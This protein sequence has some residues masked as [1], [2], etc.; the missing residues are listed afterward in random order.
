MISKIKSKLFKSSKNYSIDDIKNKISVLT[1]DHKVIAMCPQSTDGNWKGVN[2]ATSSMFHNQWLEIPQYYS[3]QVVSDEHFSEILIY[4]KNQGGEAIILNGFPAYFTKVVVMAK[5]HGLRVATVFSGGLS[6]FVGREKETISLNHIIR[7]KKEGK[8][9]RVA[10]MKAGL[11]LCLQDIL[12][13]KIYRIHPFAHK[14]NIASKSLDSDKVH[15]GVL[16]NE[17]YNKNRHNQIAAALSIENSLIHIAGN[18]EFSYW[19]ENDRII[20]H[21]DLNREDFLSLLGSMDINLYI[22]YSESWGQVITESISLGVPCLASNNSGIFDYNQKLKNSLLVNDYDNPF[23][24]AKRIKS[25]LGMDLK[26]EYLS[27]LKSLNTGAEKLVHEFKDG[28]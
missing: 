10:I 8:I 15:I 1:E 18:N 16:S 9:D 19:G 4:F 27:F 21:E 26:D 20:A 14:L 13:D 17:S 12:K 7:L 23:E 28:L 25:V 5:E 2:I 6:E 24:I 11:D 3:N 22:S